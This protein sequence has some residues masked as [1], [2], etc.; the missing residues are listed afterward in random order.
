[1][2]IL[3]TNPT[4]R[5]QSRLPTL[6]PTDASPELTAAKLVTL[7]LVGAG[8]AAT[9]IVS[10]TLHLRMPGHNIMQVLFPMGLGI[11]L[12]PR[13]GAA[14]IVALAGLAVLLTLQTFDLAKSGA[15]GF[16]CFAV[17][18]VLDLVLLRTRR[19]WQIY[20]GFVLAALG[21]NA[22]AL[23]IRGGFKL[24]NSGGAGAGG[25]G[26]GGTGGGLHKR[27]VEEWWEQAWTTFPIWGLVAGLVAASV[28]FRLRTRPTRLPPPP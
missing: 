19:G 23:F 20:L 26:G 25:G 28:W 24:A 3:G 16:T 11:A 21:T 9:F 5:A 22:V 18:P 7:V 6:T 15:A 13:L 2:R 1:M 27:T 10:P 8:I 17:G 14:T 12:V 4:L